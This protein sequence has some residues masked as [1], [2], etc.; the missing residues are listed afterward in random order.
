MSKS[1]TLVSGI[2]SHKKVKK[3]YDDWSENYDET[4]KKWNY[5]APTSLV[6]SLV[7]T[8]YRVS[9]VPSQN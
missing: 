1:N 6:V 9:K 8:N 7:I 4:L 2:G 5:K 3:Y